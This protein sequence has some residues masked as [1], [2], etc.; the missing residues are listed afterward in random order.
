MLLNCPHCKAPVPAAEINIPDNIAKCTECGQVFRISDAFEETFDNEHKTRLMLPNGIEVV[1]GLQLDI[2]LKWRKISR[3]KSYFFIGIMF[4][5]IPLV[6]LVA[7]LSSPDNVPFFVS[8]II[9]LFLLVG[10]YFLFKA[11]SFLLNTTYLSVTAFELRSE[12]R[13]IN[14][15]GW[16]NLQFPREQVTQLYVERYEESR[17]N[18]RPD[19][20]FNIM[21]FLKNREIVKL[22][23]GLKSPQVAFYLEHQIEKYLRLE[24]RLMEGEYVPGQRD[25]RLLLQAA[26]Q[27]E[28]MPVFLQRLVKN[29]L[30][31]EA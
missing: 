8:I 25:N 1:P 31:E 28:K 2:K 4:S 12:H 17:T 6:S 22:I 20:A 3:V 19:Y 26:Q 27:L 21:V 7:M 24:D 13:P 30:E 15:L 5:A 11:I 9:G 14:F 29:K 18:D 23:G 10:F 16:K